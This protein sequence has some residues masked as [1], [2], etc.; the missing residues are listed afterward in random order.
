MAYTNNNKKIWDTPIWLPTAQYRTATSATASMT[1]SKDTFGEYVY[2]L[3]GTLF[4]KYDTYNDTWIKLASPNIAAVTASSIKYTPDDGY[5]GNC[6]DATANS[7]TIAGLNGDILIGKNIKITAGT[8]IG[9]ERTITGATKQTIEETGVATAASAILLTDTT[10]RWEINQFI[11]HQVRVVYGTGSSQVR[12]VLYNDANTLYFQDPN[13]QQLETWNNTAF[14]AV[15]PYALPVAT[16]GLQAN[17]F[18]ESNIIYINEDWITQPDETSSYVIRGGGVYMLSATAA[19]PWSSFQFYDVLSDT[20]TTK[21]PLG[22]NLLAAL[23]TDF[24]IEIITKEQPYI[25]GTTT[26]ASDRVL[27]DTTLS[28]EIDRYVNYELRIV[29]GTGIGQKNRIVANGTNYFEIEK[30]F[31]INPDNTSKYEIRGGTKKIFAVGN[32]QS[33]IYQYSIDNDT[34][35]SGQ[36]YDYGQTR[37]MSVQYAGQ[38]ANAIV[39]AVRN[40]GGITVLNP[41]PTAGGTG[42]AVGDLFNITT[43]GSVGKGRVEAISAG[44]VVT[45][46]SLYSAGLTYTTGAGKATTIISGSGNNGLTVNI[47][48][49]GTVGRITTT[50]NVN[51]YKGDAITF[52][53]CNEAAWNGA[54]NVLAIDS[55]TTFDVITTATANAVASNSQGTTLVVDSVKNWTINEHVGKIIKIDIAGTSPTSQFRR[56]TSNTSNTITIPTI[57]AGVN[58]TSRYVIFGPESFG[59][60]RQYKFASESGEGRATS[61]N[62]TTLFDTT[63]TWSPNQWLGYRVRIYAGTGVGSEVAI[64]ANDATSLTLTTPGFTPDTTTK[65]RIMDTYG[66]VTGNVSVTTLGDTTKNWRVNQWAGKRV[67]ITSGTGQR[68]E[69]TIAS[70]TANI[71]TFAT[72]T[73]PDTTSTYTI[74]DVAPRSNGICLRW[75]FGSSGADNGKYLISPR[76]GATNTIDRYDIVKDVWYLSSFYSSQSEVLGIGSSYSY[77]G[78]NNFYYT[79]SIANDFIIGFALNVNT[80]QVD[81]SFQ[82]TALQGTAHTG[83][84]MEIVSS[85]DGGKFLFLGLNTSR[86]MYKTFIGN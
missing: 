33:S 14:S 3:A 32:G 24:G 1:T 11:G 16:A 35:F 57:V 76:G 54:N 39:S 60:G 73:A 45:Q 72:G 74:L 34:W 10:K 4:Y 78:A 25:T 84:L 69:L 79:Y 71:L 2:Y 13:Y 61:G 23:G 36:P 19:A 18:I 40:T 22:G 26:S 70:N 63:K 82:T 12:K 55:L 86:I 46:V 66:T 30:P 80:M 68:Q 62:A 6:L 51:L 65:Y 42:Y 38:E 50:T 81:G 59:S 58:G 17:Y 5:R 64:S 21:T 83:N 41:T 85:P 53:G 75:I 48:S 8:G 37:N 47:T 77:D 43:G 56:I 44:G 49:V 27:N 31:L 15:A 7:M 9:Q 20:W 29:S 67:V 28:L 52:S